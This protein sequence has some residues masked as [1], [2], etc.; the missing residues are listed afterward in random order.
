MAGLAAKSSG[1]RG[2][3]A[4]SGPALGRGL[5]GQQEGLSRRGGCPSARG[6]QRKPAGYPAATSQL[7][8][9]RKAA[10]PGRAGRPAPPAGNALRGAAFRP[11]RPGKSW[12]MRAGVPKNRWPAWTKTW[13]PLSCKKRQEYDFKRGRQ[14]GSSRRSRRPSGE[15]ARTALNLPAGPWKKPRL[16]WKAFPVP[17]K[18]RP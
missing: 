6:S 12:N 10:R 11:G 18:E 14:P 15:R 3:P 9:Q 8:L 4:A 5:P 7:G 2:L 16:Q 13:R 17:W 1:P